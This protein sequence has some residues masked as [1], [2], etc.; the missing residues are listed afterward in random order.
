MTRI[1]SFVLLSTLVGL[2]FNQAGLA[3]EGVKSYTDPAHVD[4]DFAIQGEYTGMVEGKN[5]QKKLGV[6]VIALGDGKFRAVGY[7]GGL[8]GDGWDGREK[9]QVESSVED[10]S[11]TFDGKYATGTITGGVM[12]VDNKEGSHIGDLKRVIRKSPTLGQQPP[13]G[14]IVL[15]DG[16]TVDGC[17]PTNS[18][19]FIK[20]STF[21]RLKINIRQV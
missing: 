7:R 16:T 13:E 19:A 4:A 6:Q 20:P 18:P 17:T 1:R 2:V 21:L 14:A 15:F 12:R 10:G 5:G 11:V 3:A 8:P 9:E